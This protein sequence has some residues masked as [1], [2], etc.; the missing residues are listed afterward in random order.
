MPTPPTPTEVV[1]ALRWLLDL[2]GATNVDP[3]SPAGRSW[4][5]RLGVELAEASVTGPELIEAARVLARRDGQFFPTPGQF[6]AAAVA[7]RLERAREERETEHRRLPAATTPAEGAYPNEPL[8]WTRGRRLTEDLE[9][10]HDLQ[11]RGHR[12]QEQGERYMAAVL[13][14]E[15]ERA[16]AGA[17]WVPPRYGPPVGVGSPLARAI[18]EAVVVSPEARSASSGAAVLGPAGNPAAAGAAR[19]TD[20]R[21]TSGPPS[22]PAT[23]EWLY[24]D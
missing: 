10:V 23:A 21:E 3:N 22:P 8:G 15:R 24:E 9:R 5:Q 2:P 11:R 14:E 12:G 7:Q 18:R 13:R 20:R 1:E 17:S 4:L 19:R 6:V 16:A